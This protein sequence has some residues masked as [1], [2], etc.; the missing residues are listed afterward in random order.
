MIP[1]KNKNNIKEDL[2]KSKWDSSPVADLR[3]MMK[4]IFK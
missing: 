2:V 3:R 4:R 1:Q